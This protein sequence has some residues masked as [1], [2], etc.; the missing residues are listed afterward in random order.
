MNRRL[1]VGVVGGR[2]G[3]TLARQCQLVGME[4]VAICDLT[5]MRCISRR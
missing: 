3:V 5:S 4:V 2:R 1:R